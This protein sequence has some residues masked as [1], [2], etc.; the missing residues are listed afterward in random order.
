[1]SDA[2]K[3]HRWLTQAELDAMLEAAR[4]EGRQQAIEDSPTLSQYR[5]AIHAAKMLEDEAR[6]AYQRGAEAMR[7]AVTKEVS[8]MEDRWSNIILA[9]EA[10][11]AEASDKIMVE[12]DCL[13]DVVDLIARV[14]VPEDKS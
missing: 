3:V 9:C 5:D 4:Q 6:M 11:G 12:H 14:A 13:R 1:M 10:K 7:E 2:E 8:V